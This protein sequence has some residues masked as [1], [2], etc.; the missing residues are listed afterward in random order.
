MLRAFPNRVIRSIE[1]CRIMV[2][3]ANF[4]MGRKTI[5]IPRE[6]KGFCRSRGLT[7]NA[8]AQNLSLSYTSAWGEKSLKLLRKMKDSVSPGA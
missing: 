6:N 4:Y 1:H 8:G 2:S 5:E 7:E 3:I